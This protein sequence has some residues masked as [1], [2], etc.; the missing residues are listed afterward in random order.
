MDDVIGGWIKSINYELT[1][2]F[3]AQ[4]RIALSRR[5]ISVGQTARLGEKRNI[6]RNL[7]EK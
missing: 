4:Y 7:V 2:L 5:I 1:N 6:Y 3:L